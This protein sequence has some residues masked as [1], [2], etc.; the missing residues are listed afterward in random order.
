MTKKIY[1]IQKVTDLSN[2]PRITKTLYTSLVRPILEYG[3]CVWC[4]QFSTYKDRI[5]SVQ[6]NFLIFAL[7]G[8]NWNSNL[9][10]PSY[11]NRLL[12]LNLP[13]LANRRTM[14]G[15]VFIN[16]LIN[17]DID[18]DDLVSRLH[19]SVP[20]RLTRNYIPLTLPSCRSNYALHEPFRVLCSDY[21]KYYFII[22]NS[23]STNNLKL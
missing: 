15:V 16:N 23:Q 19:F 17:G 4:P 8:L 13:S 6:K 10:L 2:D 22:S 20:C 11:T 14:L 5:E 1:F 21:N 3:S 9:R 12:L 18:S 7:R